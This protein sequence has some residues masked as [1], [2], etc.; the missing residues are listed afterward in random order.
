MSADLVGMNI[1][2]ITLYYG[3]GVKSRVYAFFLYGT[4]D[5]VAATEHITRSFLN[6]DT[7]E[8]NYK[9]V[10]KRYP[11]KTLKEHGMSKNCKNWVK[12]GV[13][14]LPVPESDT[15]ALLGLRRCQG[16]FLLHY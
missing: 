14:L 1:L 9:S 3:I 15:C 11:H 2:D 6:N 7:S 4:T 10:T 13:T 16:T 5:N 8:Q 12:G